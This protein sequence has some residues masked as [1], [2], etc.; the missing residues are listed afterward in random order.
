MQPSDTIEVKTEGESEVTLSFTDPKLAN[1]K[2]RITAEITGQKLEL[3]ATALYEIPQVQSNK[4]TDPQLKIFKSN[5]ALTALN[6]FNRLPKIQAA[7]DKARDGSP[8]KKEVGKTLDQL[9]R[10][11]HFLQEIDGLYQA[12]NNKGKIHYRVFILYGKY[13]KVELFTTQVPVVQPVEVKDDNQNSALQPGPD[14]QPP[15]KPP[16]KPTTKKKPQ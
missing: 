3:K 8:R 2:V 13:N 1:F 9:K 11:V 5:E 14:Q 12:L 10:A 15:K 7:F 4:I 6:D 16:K